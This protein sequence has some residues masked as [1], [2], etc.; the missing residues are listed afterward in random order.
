MSTSTN[1]NIRKTFK[2]FFFIRNNRVSESLEGLNSS[3]NQSADKLWPL[4]KYV[5]SYL[6][7]DLKSAQFFFFEP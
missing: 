5:Q 1:I 3:L 7:W 2:N 4:V 6:L